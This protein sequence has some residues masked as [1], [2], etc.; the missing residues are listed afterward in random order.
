[1]SAAINLAEFRFTGG[2][3][4]FVKHLNKGNRFCTIPFYMEGKRTRGNRNRLQYN[5]SYT[6]NV[7]AFATR[8]T[9]W[10]ADTPFRLPLGADALD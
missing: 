4:E 1:M 7:F 8:S 3:G 6:E 5:D 2:I 10:T 9:P